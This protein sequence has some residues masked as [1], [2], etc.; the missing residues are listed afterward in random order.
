MKRLAIIGCGDLG[1]QIAW[2]AQ[3]EGNYSIAGFFDDSHPGNEPI[4]KYNFLGR[5]ADIH[6]SFNRREFDELMIGI[7][8]KHMGVRSELFLRYSSEIPFATIIHPSAYV[9][10]SAEV[11]AGSIIY[12]GCVIDLGVVIG[13]NVLLNAGCVIAH[14]SR[15]GDHSFFSPAVN[16]AGFINI[17]PKVILGIGTVVIDNLHV[18]EYTR[19]GAGAVITQSVVSP[20][21]YVGVPAKKI[22]S[23]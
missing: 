1:M 16:L 17:A 15:V 23:L 14:D 9:D 10:R 22:K 21:L 20:G 19:S 18:C 4:G 3:S 7:G 6:D 8:Y 12:P 5:S 11:G 2:H 13:R